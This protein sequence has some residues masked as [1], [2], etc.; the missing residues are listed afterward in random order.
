L[1]A[2]GKEG[3][4][5]TDMMD[6]LRSHSGLDTILG[7]NPINNNRWTVCAHATGLLSPSQ[8]TGSI[9]A[10]SPPN[11]QVHAFATGSSTPCTSTFKYAYSRG[12]SLPESYAPGEKQANLA[13]YWW[14]AE[15]FNRIALL[16]YHAFSEEFIPERKNFEESLV[17]RV[18][19][20]EANQDLVNESFL[21]CDSLMEA[22]AQ[23]HA[24]EPPE[25]TALKGAKFLRNVDKKTGLRKY[26]TY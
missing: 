15:R 14:R 18:M 16:H 2:I 6:A 25:L 13:A 4:Q 12:L 17:A 9:V 23:H 1:A 20:Q 26:F 11:G 21:R 22:F 5:L 3:I 7:S 10:W 24:S 19:Q 8:T